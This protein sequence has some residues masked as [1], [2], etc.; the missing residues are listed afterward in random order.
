VQSVQKL[1]V[2]LVRRGDL[3][4]I[5]K[6]HR[7]GHVATTSGVCACNFGTRV[8]L[9]ARTFGGAQSGV[10]H[11]ELVR[12]FGQCEI[13]MFG[14]NAWAF[15]LCEAHECVDGAFVSRRHFVGFCCSKMEEN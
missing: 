1:V 7:I 8:V 13:R 10:S 6:I 12:N 14:F 5:H 15:F 2:N 9:A 3:D 4:L 11:A